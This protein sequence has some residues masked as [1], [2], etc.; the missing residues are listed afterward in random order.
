MKDV[1]DS[2]FVPNRTGT[3]PE[4]VAAIDS[5]V[6]TGCIVDGEAVVGSEGRLNFPSDGID[7]PV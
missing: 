6:P 2:P 3:F 7:G 4:P 5:S 1:R